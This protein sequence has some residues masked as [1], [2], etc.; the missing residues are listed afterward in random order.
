MNKDIKAITDVAWG[1]KKLKGKTIAE[2]VKSV[3]KSFGLEEED[4][5]L[6]EKVLIEFTTGVSSP[7]G[8]GGSLAISTAL[9]YLE[10]AVKSPDGRCSLDSGDD[11]SAEALRDVMRNYVI[12]CR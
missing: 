12:N 2:A 7:E 6:V 5:F 8:N 1:V 3:T 9:D 11:C 4:A 10:Q